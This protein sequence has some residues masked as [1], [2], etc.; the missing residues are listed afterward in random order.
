MEEVFSDVP[1]IPVNQW[2]CPALHIGGGDRE[3]PPFQTKE[4]DSFV[5]DLYLRMGFDKGPILFSPRS[6]IANT[7]S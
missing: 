3:P 7:T 5:R 2:T 6:I 1:P 4:R